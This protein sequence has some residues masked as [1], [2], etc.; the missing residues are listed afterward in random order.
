MIAINFHSQM[1]YRL[2][3]VM[4]SLLA[5]HIFAFIALTRQVKEKP[6]KHAY[7]QSGLISAIGISMVHMIGMR[8]IHVDYDIN[9][10]TVGLIIAFLISFVFASLAFKEFQVLGLRGVAVE[11]PFLMIK[12]GVWMGLS[13]SGLHYIAIY[14]AKMEH[15]HTGQ[16][17]RYPLINSTILGMAVIIMVILFMLIFIIIASLNRKISSQSEKL[18]IN[19]QYYKALFNQNPDTILTFDLQGK[20]LTA[21]HAFTASFGYTLEEIGNK[22]FTPF[23]A[24]RAVEKTYQQFIKCSKGTITN[25]ESVII[26]KQGMERDVNITKIQKW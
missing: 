18:K 26:D 7:I 15:L 23:L 9:F 11:S 13:I 22:E 25:F 3:N 1:E 12:S 16:H 8:S 19:E 17:Y 6:S 20:F 4:L 2:F 5:G 24:P 14:S 21:N 10:S